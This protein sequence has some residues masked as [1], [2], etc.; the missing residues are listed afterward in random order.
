MS[1]QPKYLLSEINLICPIN[2]G[3]SK[4]ILTIA[5]R[6]S[7][8]VRISK[9]GWGA[10]LDKE[11]KE[12][13]HH[14]KKVLFIV[15]MPSPEFEEKLRQDG[16]ILEIIDHHAMYNLDRTNKLSSLEQFAEL[17]G[18]QLSRFE[19]A[20]ALNDRGYI[21]AM[22]DAGYT[23]EEIKKVRAYDLQAQAESQQ[24]AWEHIRKISVQAK[25]EAELKHGILIAY[26]PSTFN[27]YLLDLVLL[28]KP[29]TIIDLLI[30][31]KLDDGTIPLVQFFG[32]KELVQHLYAALGGF[33]GGA[34][35]D[36]GFWGL[37]EH[38][39]LEKIFHV[40]YISE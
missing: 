38:I 31:T 14:L 19:K 40:L 17:V 12:N 10:R 35:D 37:K 15:E 21:Y 8:D 5:K 33:M 30:I 23:L 39:S 1:M 7:I 24:I 36:S 20:V 3:E 11:P 29:D 27:M 26:L 22:R 9:Q 13:L 2:D 25:Q 16:H 32:R 28:E 6:L 34:R 4:T 18:Y